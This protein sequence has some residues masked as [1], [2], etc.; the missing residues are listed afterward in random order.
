MTTQTPTDVVLSAGRG[1]ARGSRLPV[2]EPTVRHTAVYV[3]HRGR[4]PLLKYNHDVDIV[5]F[6]GRLVVVVSPPG[7]HCR[8]DVGFGDKAVNCGPP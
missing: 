7:A 2:Y 6:G 5:R 8:G 4:Q 3:P 1:S